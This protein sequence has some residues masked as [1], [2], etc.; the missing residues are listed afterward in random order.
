[1]FCNIVITKSLKI[2]SAGL[3]N[4]DKYKS[5]LKLMLTN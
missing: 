2:I 3:T 5:A 1:M 4:L